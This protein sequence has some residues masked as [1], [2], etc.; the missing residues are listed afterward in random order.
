[1]PHLSPKGLR[2]KLLDRLRFGAR[3]IS[4][5]VGAQKALIPIFNAPLIKATMASR[6]ST[7][8]PIDLAA[9]EAEAEDRRGLGDRDLSKLYR[10]WCP[11]VVVRTLEYLNAHGLEEEGLYRVPG[12][13][14]T[15]KRLKA[16]FDSQGDLVLESIPRR[17]FVH[18]LQI[19][20]VASLFKQFLR[21]LPAP[22]ITQI[23]VARLEAHLGEPQLLREVISAELDAYE[24]YLLSMLCHHLIAVNA[25]SAKNKMDTH[26]LSIVFCSSSNLGIGS[27][28]FTALMDAEVW[29]NLFCKREADTLARERAAN[30]PAPITTTATAQTTT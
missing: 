17:E 27:N 5:S 2:T 16:A 24:F 13:S 14:E 19:A 21:D 6:I 20:D 4:P 8:A 12:S 18:G 30:D 3:D 28:V 11:A 9:T 10:F 7:D 29:T 15:I 23:V 1:M 25:H 22:M 26:N